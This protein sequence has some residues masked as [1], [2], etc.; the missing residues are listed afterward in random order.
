MHPRNAVRS[1]S[2]AQGAPRLA[3]RRAPHPARFAA[4]ALA[5][6]LAASTLALGETYAVVPDGSHAGYRV[7]ERVAGL[8]L[9]RDAVGTTDGVTGQVVLGSDGAVMDGSVLSVDLTGLRSDEARRDRYIQGA[10]LDTGTY[11]DAVLTVHGVDGLPSPLPTG[12]SA[13]V[14]I[15]G[16]LAV[17][18]TTVATTWRGT[19]TFDGDT[20]TV[21]A[22]TDVTFDDLG[23]RRP[24]IGPIL[25]VSDPI[26]LAVTVVVR[27][28]AP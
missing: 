17:H 8:K 22:A 6:V 26:H 20:V 12:G 27:P 3:P 4:P 16:D 15:V 13:D 7:S 2:R 14:T 9:P 1:S 25:A 10:T 19:A 11:P 24:V 23:L 28:V 18:G 21:D 5:L